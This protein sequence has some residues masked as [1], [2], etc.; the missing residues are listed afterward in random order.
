MQQFFFKLR[1]YKNIQFDLY[2]FIAQ[3]QLHYSSFEIKIFL[4]ILANIS[5]NRPITID[6]L[7]ESF[8]VK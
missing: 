7:Q 5:K 3:C 6:V 8:E 1:K 4:E 2:G